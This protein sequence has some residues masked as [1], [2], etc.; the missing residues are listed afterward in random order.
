M[1]TICERHNDV[2]KDVCACFI[3]YENGKGT[4]LRNSNQHG[5]T[6]GSVLSPCVF[7]VYKKIILIKRSGNLQRYQHTRNEHKQSKIRP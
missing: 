6:Q 4:L 7:N 2:Q 3:G 1:R 5:V